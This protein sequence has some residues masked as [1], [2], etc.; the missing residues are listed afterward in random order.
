MTPSRFLLPAALL[1]ALAGCASTPPPAAVEV[2]STAEPV[3]DESA[4]SDRDQQV[5]ASDAFLSAHPD[6]RYRGLGVRA[7]RDGE[8]DQAL[9]YFTRGAYYADKASQA[10]IGELYWTGQGVEVDRARAYAWMDLAAERRYRGFL[11]MRERYWARLDEAERARALEIGD[12][13]YAEYGDAVARPRLA[14]AIR[15]ATATSMVSR[16]ALSGA[17]I[18]VTV[19]GP[20]GESVVIND[21]FNRRYWNPTEYFRWQDEVWRAPQRRARVSVG[22][23]EALG[24]GEE[25]A[26]EAPAE[27][28]AGD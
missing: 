27:P 9:E 12:G 3:V 6:L 26:A 10:M 17:P 20:A 24:A 4:L 1:A 23:L 18:T 25:A 19:P 7:Y 15:R 16:P 2:L 28:A 22:E 11:A 8:L 14:T 13:L 21:F 5:L